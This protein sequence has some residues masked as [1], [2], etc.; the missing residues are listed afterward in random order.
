MFI[1]CFKPASPILAFNIDTKTISIFK[2]LFMINLEWIAMMIWVGLLQLLGE[3][4][5]FMISTGPN[6][7]I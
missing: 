2:K 3:K 1:V 6:D 7:I 5:I 4:C